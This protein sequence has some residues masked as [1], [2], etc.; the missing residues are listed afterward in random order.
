MFYTHP[1]IVSFS[2]ISE[3]GGS[4]PC[5]VR[6]GWAQGGCLVREVIEA[7]VTRVQMKSQIWQQI[8]PVE[9]K[10]ENWEPSHGGNGAGSE[11]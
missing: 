11:S 5:R 3:M 2:V 4:V 7:L 10:S 6:S 1:F 9:G 8:P